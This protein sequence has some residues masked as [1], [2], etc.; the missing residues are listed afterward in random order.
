MGLIYIN[1]HNK[2]VI[3]EHFNNEKKT[4]AF[5]GMREP[6]GKNNKKNY[7]YFS[8]LKNIIK[9]VLVTFIEKEYVTHFINGLAI[10]SD[11]LCASVVIELKKDYK[12][13]LEAAI[14]CFNQDMYWNDE[15]KI[16]YQKILSLCDTKNY[17]TAGNYTK[18]CM[19]IRNRY[20]V[21]N[22]DIVIAI[23]NGKS[24]G[25]EKTVKYAKT[26]KKPIIIIN[27]DDIF[28]ENLHKGR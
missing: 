19:H 25:T 28:N 27:P 10:G 24:G 16:N 1:S 2:L 13:T 12:I 14:P 15:D 4:I 6:F 9:E 23:W 21:D 17:I 5:T 11:Q 22:S 7:T 8:K 20:M 26:K 3:S 18:I